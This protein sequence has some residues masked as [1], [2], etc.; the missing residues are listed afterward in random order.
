MAASTEQREVCSTL[1]QE[2][3]P[4]LPVQ[5]DDTSSTIFH[6]LQY[7]LPLPPVLTSITSSTLFHYL[8]YSFLLPPVL[9]L[10]T[11]STL[12]Y[13]LQY[14]LSLPPV[15]FLITSSALFHYLQPSPQKASSV[16]LEQLIL[17]LLELQAKWRGRP[18][19]PDKE[20]RVVREV[21]LKEA[22]QAF[23]TALPTVHR[24]TVGGV[25]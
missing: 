24:Y 13:Y 8:Q 3:A 17:A 16:L 19:A 14:S 20:L 7:S 5:A 9:S 23:A 1:L 2:H 21:L 22:L 25:P 6:Y 12:S 18:A 15:L 11:S 4:I 10:I